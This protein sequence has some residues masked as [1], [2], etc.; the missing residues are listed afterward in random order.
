MKYQFTIL[1]ALLFKS[2]IAQLPETDIFLCTIKKDASEYI[3]SK[4]VN[5]TDHKGYDNQPCFTP[6]GKR[7]LYVSVSDTTQSDI[8]SYD[9]EAKVS[10]QFTETR[11]SEYSPSY[12]RDNKFI[13]VVRVDGDSGQRFYR[14]PIHNPDNALLVKNSDSIGYSCW[15]TETNLAMFILGP[16]NTL[17][18][19]NTKTSERKLIASDI[20]RCLKLSHDGTKMYFVLKSNPSEWYIYSMDCKDYMLTRITKTLPHCEDFA[21]MPDGSL[22][23]GSEGKLYISENNSDWKM[24]ADFTSELSNFYRLAINNDGTLLALVAFTG[25]KP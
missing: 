5:I 1:I 8:Y 19:L 24:I 21:V 20:G 16:A 7:I 12:T 14:L 25:K 18:V 3:F 22:L 4:P 9:L 23:L 11:E 17:Q 15:L 13:S 6:D 2:G 10:I